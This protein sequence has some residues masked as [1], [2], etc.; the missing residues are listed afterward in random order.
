MIDYREAIKKISWN[1]E[2]K[3]LLMGMWSIS[4]HFVV[5][6]NTYVSQKSDVR[7]SHRMTITNVCSND[8]I[9]WFLY[10]LQMKKKKNRK[11][12]N[13]KLLCKFVIERLWFKMIYSFPNQSKQTWNE[14]ACTFNVATKYLF[15]V[16][17]FRI[18]IITYLSAAKNV[19]KTQQ[20]ASMWTLFAIFFSFA[21]PYE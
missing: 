16:F 20:K 4:L 21:L 7:L 9:E 1:V 3:I 8:F 5:A 12:N 6:S 18:S 10:T 19:K 17:C 14:S 15:V 2:R 13:Q 11:I